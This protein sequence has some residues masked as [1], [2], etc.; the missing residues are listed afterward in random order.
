MNSKDPMT[1]IEAS[2]LAKQLIESYPDRE[3]EISM[4]DEFSYALMRSEFAKLGRQT[5]PDGDFFVVKVY[6]LAPHSN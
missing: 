5:G 2:M 4:P 6:P 3:F 1:E